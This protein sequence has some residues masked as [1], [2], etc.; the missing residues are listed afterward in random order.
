MNRNLKKG[1]HNSFK[2][3]WID[4]TSK[5]QVNKGQMPGHVNNLT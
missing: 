5:K 3:S 4:K 2:G 1:A